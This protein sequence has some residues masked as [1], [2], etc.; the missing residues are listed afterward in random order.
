MG[1]TKRKPVRMSLANLNT[2]VS[3]SAQFNPSELEEKI[4]V[5]YAKLSVLGLSHKPQQYQNTDSLDFDFELAF[6][7]F[8]DD[9]NKMDDVA[10]ARRF[11]MSLCYKRRGSTTVV[12]G[13]PPRVLFVWPKLISLSAI[14][15]SLTFRHAKFDPDGPPTQFAVKVGLE[16]IRDTALFSEDVLAN[17]TLRPTVATK[18]V[19]SL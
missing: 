13:A 3:I 14:V 10:Y 12:G 17:G 2:G 6:R 11:L 7:S 9:G 15:T 19:G 4:S 18:G 16:E 8:D 1:L 5:N